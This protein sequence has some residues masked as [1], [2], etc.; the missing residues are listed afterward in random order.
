MHAMFS[1][2]N[3]NYSC[4]SNCASVKIG[5]HAFTDIIHW[6]KEIAAVQICIMSFVL[7]LQHGAC[8]S[9]Y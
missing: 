3:S 5:E 1:F 4:K 8:I 7:I 2:H 9:V 6:I